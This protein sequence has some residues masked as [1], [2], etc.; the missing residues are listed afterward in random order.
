[1]DFR[2]SRTGTRFSVA[3]AT[4]GW[5]IVARP[6]F[7]LSCD[8]P[9]GDEVSFT[10]LRNLVICCDGTN[11]QFGTNNTNVIRLIQV[12]DRDPT[13]QLLYYDPGVGTLPEPN[14]FTAM[15]KWFSKVNGLA[16]GAGLAHKV[17]QA[18]GYLMDTWEPEDRVYLFG[19]SRGAYAVRVLA[20]LL[21]SLGLLPRGNTNLVPYVLRLYE[22]VRDGGPG[23]PGGG[24]SYWALCDSFRQTF[25]RDVP[26]VPERRF[27]VHFLGVWD[28]VSSYGWAYNP[29]A[30]PF[31]R[32]NPSVHAVRHAV[33]IDER[34]CFF[35]Q[36]LMDAQPD[37]TFDQ[38]WFPGVH[39]DVGGGYPEAGGGLW[40]EPFAWMLEGAEAALLEVDEAR[41]K[42]LLGRPPVSGMPWGD[43]IHDSLT[44]LWKPAEYIPKKVWQPATQTWG[45]KL[46]RG[47]PR[48]IAEGA[49][50]HR[51]AL[52]RIQLTPGYEP[53]NLSADFRSRVRGLKNEDL[54]DSMPYKP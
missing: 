36:N 7:A 18:Y 26:G 11:N 40:R 46:G 38:Q 35:R 27:P 16:F 37:Q 22:S 10:M 25:A 33:S 29:K 34:R 48:A 42:D 19:F 43:E 5:C 20:G 50:L 17:G 8:G 45:M 2:P 52:K 1:M 49:L 54:P 4:A 3:L 47:R 51:S 44:K 41:L 13:K 24:T 31:T 32:S 30:F 23:G 14:A 9:L 21:H 12:L 6:W 28:T 39:C 15:Q 53:A